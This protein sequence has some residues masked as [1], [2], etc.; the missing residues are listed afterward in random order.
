MYQYLIDCI[1][2]YREIGDLESTDRKTDEEDGET[3]SDGQTDTGDSP[4]DQVCVG[5][6]LGH[7][8]QVES[9][10]EIHCPFN[11]N[12][13]TCMKLLIKLIFNDLDL[14]FFSQ[15]EI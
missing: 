2:D 9:D 13:C 1:T 12:A 10:K 14:F 11:P 5:Q 7:T 15:G 6:P 4:T 8:K 3:Q